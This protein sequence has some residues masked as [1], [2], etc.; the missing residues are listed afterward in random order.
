MT[1]VNLESFADLI[2]ERLRESGETAAGA[3]LRAGLPRDAIRSVLRGHPPTFVRAAEICEALGCEFYMGPPR[4]DKAERRVYSPRWADRFRSELRTGF[5]VDMGKLLHEHRS[6]LVGNMREWLDEA[7]A[8]R[9]RTEGADPSKWA[10]LRTLIVSDEVGSVTRDGMSFVAFHKDWLARRGMSDN[11]VVL[12]VSRDSMDPI[13]PY[14]SMLLLDRGR[15]K[16]QAGRLYMLLVDHGPLRLRRAVWAHERWMMATNS[17]G[18]PL[19]PWPPEAEVLGEAR[20]LAHTVEDLFSN[21]QT[22]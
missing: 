15:R 22:T 19:E 16:P 6:R 3:A 2:R 7:N 14:D 9:A 21:S 4:G 10:A 18:Q 12:L 1:S 11:C 5:R 8:A 20:H 17:P 13:P